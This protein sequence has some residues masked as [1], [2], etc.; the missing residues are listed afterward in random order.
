LCFHALCVQ[1]FRSAQ[2][3]AVDEVP[4]KYINGRGGWRKWKLKEIDGIDGVLMECKMA[5]QGN[6]F[7][8]QM[9]EVKGW[10]AECRSELLGAQ[11]LEE[12][13]GRSVH[14]SLFSMFSQP[15]SWSASPSVLWW[16]ISSRSTGN[17]KDGWELGTFLAKE[18]GWGKKRQIFPLSHFQIIVRGKAQE[19]DGKWGKRSQQKLVRGGVAHFWPNPCI[20]E[21]GTKGIPNWHLVA[22]IYWEFWVS[23]KAKNLA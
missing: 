8:G 11:K 12:L 9:E 20:V 6:V 10:L 5:E 1:W 14:L 2:F 15:D 21:C 7:N 22:V 19:T 13:A 4:F 18:I 16:G 17:L 3:V 23:E